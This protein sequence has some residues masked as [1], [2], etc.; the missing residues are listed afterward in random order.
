VRGA[1]ETSGWRLMEYNQ[2]WAPQ[3][4]AAR[5]D[6]SG[7]AIGQPTMKC[8]VDVYSD[9][10]HR[11]L[12]CRRSSVRE[13]IIC[14]SGLRWAKYAQQ[15]WLQCRLVL[16]PVSRR[17]RSDNAPESYSPEPAMTKCKLSCM[18]LRLS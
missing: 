18:R 7:R 17:R 8:A 6:A 5:P 1:L 15:N 13:H 2:R 12:R 11:V 10:S 9:W 3:V 4:L 16:H 14:S